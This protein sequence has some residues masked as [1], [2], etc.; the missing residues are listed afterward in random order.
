MADY[1][2][3]YCRGTNQ[4]VHGLTLVEGG[5][6]DCKDLSLPTQSGGPRLLPTPLKFPRWQEIRICVDTQLAPMSSFPPLWALRRLYIS[7]SGPRGSGQQAVRGK[8]T[9]PFWAEASKSRCMATE[10]TMLPVEQL[11]QRAASFRLV[12]RA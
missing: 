9:C 4:C 6:P 1:R 12:P 5:N 11:Q 10:E 7:C 8:D 3:R 2:L